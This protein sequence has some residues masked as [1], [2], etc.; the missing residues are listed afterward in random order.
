MGAM[1][2]LVSDCARAETSTRIK[3][4]LRALILSDWKSEPDQQKDQNFAKNQYATIKT[5]NNR[6]LNLSGDS[7]DWWLLAL[8]FVCHV[9]SQLAS[10]VL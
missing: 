1:D 3:D 9:L 8:Q 10:A 2:I 6:V 7:A 5:A 4:I